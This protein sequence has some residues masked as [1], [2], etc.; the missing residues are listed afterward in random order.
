MARLYHFALD[1]FCRRIRLMLAEYGE[2]PEL[3]ASPPWQPDAALFDFTPPAEM[4]LLVDDDGATAAGALA[5][6]EYLLETRGAKKNLTGA[7]AAQ[8]AEARRL[9]AFFDGRMYM[10]A[11]RPVLMEK[12]LRRK[13]PRE[14]GGGAPDTRRL[15]AAVQRVAAYLEVIDRLAEQR[16]LLAGDELTLA[17]LAAAAHLSALE[18]LDALNWGDFATAKVWYQRIKSR[19]AFR[20]LLTDRVA[21]VAPAAVY[22]QLD[23]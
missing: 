9:S 1:P 8:R 23:F 18:Y 13:L 2:T 11:T 4:P 3:V 16:G 17:D 21:G 6:G 15:R 19:P 22:S 5:A 10:D 12:V 14:Q 7:T 20:P